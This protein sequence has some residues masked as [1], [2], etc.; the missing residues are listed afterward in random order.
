MVGFQDQLKTVETIYECRNA[1]STFLDYNYLNYSLTKKGKKIA[2]IKLLITFLYIDKTYFLK[3]ILPLIGLIKIDRKN[4]E[5]NIFL[6]GS[7]D[8]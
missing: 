8:I 4:I 7:E 1:S 3:K 2:I 6:F 5:V